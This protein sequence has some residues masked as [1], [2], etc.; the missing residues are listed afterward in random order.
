[1]GLTADFGEGINRP[2][3][4]L[5]NAYFY[6]DHCCFMASSAL[7]GRSLVTIVVLAVVALSL[8]FVPELLRFRRGSSS[9][10]E[11]S[12]NDQR[13]DVR[14][15]PTKFPSYEEVPPFGRGLQEGESQQGDQTDLDIVLGRFE[16]GR[17]DASSPLLRSPTGQRQLTTLQQILADAPISWSSL[18]SKMALRSISIQQSR[19]VSILRLIPVGVFPTSRDALVDLSA[20]LSA[21]LRRDAPAYGSL[22]DFMDRLDELDGTATKAMQREQV[23][24]FVYQKWQDVNLSPL[25]NDATTAKRF[26]Y[27]PP[28]ITEILLIDLSLGTAPATQ[29][30]RKRFGVTLDFLVAAQE[31]YT[32][33]VWR[34][35]TRIF[36]QEAAGIETIKPS[37]R[38]LS[39][40]DSLAPMTREPYV[41]R[42]MSERGFWYEK[43][44]QIF[45]R[46]A[47]L[48]NVRGILKFPKL[49]FY[50]LALPIDRRVDRAFAAGA[51]GSATPFTEGGSSFAGDG[52]SASFW[53]GGGDRF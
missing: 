27:V 4:Q 50:D 45:T 46:G 8:F 49:P 14:R 43:H 13:K 10:K 6:R 17:Y 26:S 20:L 37:W 30:R 22:Y 3:S 23:P 29:D 41:V 34:R 40:S 19:I 36:R 9:E 48:E 51:F 25:V 42:I 2:F 12:A 31:R 38:R 21:V 15:R 53:G 32:F 28:F 11:E 52:S 44:Y 18:G 16:E 33:E 7:S 5:A 47:Y 1:M 39:V 24:L 35:K